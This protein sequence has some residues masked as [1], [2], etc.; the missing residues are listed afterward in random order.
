MLQL[1]SLCVEDQRERLIVNFHCRLIFRIL[2]DDSSSP[3][4]FHPLLLRLS[5]QYDTKSCRAHQYIIF[6]PNSASRACRT[7]CTSRYAK[8]RIREYFR[9]R[10]LV[11]P[12]MI[13]NVI[14]GFTE[15]G[16]WKTGH[17]R[18]GWKQKSLRSGGTSICIMLEIC[19]HFLGI[20]MNVPSED[21]RQE[22]RNGKPDRPFYTSFTQVGCSR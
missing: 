18:Q 4:P 7:L 22:A 9:P 10:S 5:E 13:F 8:A 3:R 12:Y 17:G 19:G 2:P 1:D 6:D 15:R 14:A 11:N 20:L 16:N 21:R